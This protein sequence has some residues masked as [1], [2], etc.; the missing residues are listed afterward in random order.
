MQKRILIVDDESL[1]TATLSRLLENNGCHA[2]KAHA[3]EEALVIAQKDD[4][5]LIICDIRMPGLD[6][7]TTVKKI[8][9]FRINIPA[10]FMTGFTNQ[11]IEKEA[12][13]FTSAQYIEKPLDLMDL[14]KAIKSL[15]REL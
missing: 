13:L 15:I 11:T 12:R 1:V 10:I 8:R 14:M 4:F 7:L 3:G 5:D 9:E 2:I 6:G